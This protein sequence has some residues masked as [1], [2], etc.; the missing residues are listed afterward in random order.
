MTD[1]IYYVCAAVVIIAGTI[2]YQY[3]MNPFWN[4]MGLPKNTEPEEDDAEKTVY[5]KELEFYREIWKGRKKS[6]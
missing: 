1:Y 3:L 6:E 2:L 5:E 4:K